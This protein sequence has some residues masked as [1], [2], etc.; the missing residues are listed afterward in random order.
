[1]TARRVYVS[2][3]RASSLAGAMEYNA[4]VRV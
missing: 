2:V 4:I 1:M 3:L